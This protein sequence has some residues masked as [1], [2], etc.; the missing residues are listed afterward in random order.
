MN[1]LNRIKN[2]CEIK[3]ITISFLEQHLEFGK[4]TI[5]KWNRSS[6][7]SDKLTKI[8]D[9]FH[10][11]TD[12]LLD[13]EPNHSFYDFQFSVSRSVHLTEEDKEKLIKTFKDIANLYLDAKNTR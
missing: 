3:G 8:A 11:S 10:V 12:Y 7:N 4:G 9:Y 5:V 13:R 1:I 2:L 6:P